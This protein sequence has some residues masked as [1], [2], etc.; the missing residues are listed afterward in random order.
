MIQVRR[1]CLPSP[2]PEA[3]AASDSAGESGGTSEAPLAC[4]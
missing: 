3:S 4:W 2:M 1:R